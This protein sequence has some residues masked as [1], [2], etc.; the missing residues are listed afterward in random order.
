[1]YLKDEY[2]YIYIYMYIYM[3]VCVCVCVRTLPTGFYRHTGK[4]RSGTLQKPEN[5]DPSGTLQ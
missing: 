1:M 4:L 5:R 3:C 2:I